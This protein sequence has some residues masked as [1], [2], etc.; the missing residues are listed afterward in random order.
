MIYDVAS[1]AI[2]SLPSSYKK[3]IVSELPPSNRLGAHKV[4]RI[5]SARVAWHKHQTHVAVRVLEA[6]GPFS[7][8]AFDGARLRFATS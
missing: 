1:L 5:L 7:A 3:R 6:V 8:T 2:S 4:M